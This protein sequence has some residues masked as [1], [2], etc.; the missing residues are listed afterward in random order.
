MTRK[1]RMILVM[2]ILLGVLLCGAAGADES[3]QVSVNAGFQCVVTRPESTAQLKQTV[4]LRTFS[5]TAVEGVH[6]KGSGTTL[7]FNAGETRKSVVMSYPVSISPT[8]INGVSKYQAGLAR[9][10]GVELMDEAG[11][12]LWSGVFSM[13]RDEQY[14]VQPQMINSKVENLL[15]MKDSDFASDMDGR[16]VD[17]SI[18]SPIGKEVTDSGYGQGKKTMNFSTLYSSVPQEYLKAIGGK[19]Y[20][21]AGFQ[22]KEEDDGW[23]YIQIL[24][25]E[26]ENYDEKDPKGD[27]D[28]PSKSVYKACFELSG[29]GDVNTSY[30]NQFFPHKYNSSSRL[31]AYAMCLI[32]VN[33]WAEF[34]NNNSRL[35]GQKFRTS[36]Y[37]ATDTGA[38]VLPASTNSLTIRFDAR[39]EDD[40]DWYYKDL[41][42][43]AA[44]CDNKAPQLT[45]VMVGN[46]SYAPGGSLNISLKFDEIV[47]AAGT[48]LN[49]SWGTLTC[50]FCDFTPCDVVTYRGAFTA[51]NVSA[52]ESLRITGIT[53]TIRDLAGNEFGAMEPRTMS[54]AVAAQPYNYSITYHLEGGT[55]TG[56]PASYTFQTDTFTLKYPTRKGFKFVGWTGYGL[57]GIVRDVTIPK[58]SRGRRVYTAIWTR[59]MDHPIEVGSWAELQSALNEGGAIRL[60]QDITAGAGD[61]TLTAPEGRDTH[62]DLAGH[63]LHRGLRGSLNGGNVITVRGELIVGDSAR[64]GKITGGNNDCFNAGDPITLGGGIYVV[65][66][67]SFTLEGGTI[68]D[69]RVKHDSGGNKAQGGGVYVAGGGSFTMKGGAIR[70]CLADAEAYYAEGGAVYVAAGASFTMTGGTISSCRAMIYRS[71]NEVRGGGIY[72]D[73][74]G[75]FTMTGGTVTNCRVRFMANESKAC[76]G[77]NVYVARNG[78]FNISGSPVIADHVGGVP[79]FQNIFLAIGVRIHVTAAL[80]ETARISL[81]T[82]AIPA[83]NASTVIADCP[84]G[85]GAEVNFVSDRTGYLFS[86]GNDEVRLMRQAAITSWA[87]LQEKLN[88][89]GYVTLTHNLTA[90]END[91]ALVIPSNVTVHLNLN[92]QKLDRGLGDQAARPGG[93]VLTVEGTLDLWDS[94][95]YSGGRVTGANNTGNGGGIYVAPGGTLTLSYGSPIRNNKAVNGGGV[96][97]SAGSTFSMYDL[98]AVNQN[99]RQDGKPSNIYLDHGTVINI[100]RTLYPY[101]TSGVTTAAIPTRDAPVVITS[102]LSGRGGVGGFKSDMSGC[103][104]MLNADSECVLGVIDFAQPDFRLPAAI[105][106][107]E[108]GAFEGAAMHVVYVPDG[109]TSVG[110]NAFLDCKNLT[111]IR[112]PKDCTIDPAAFSGCD[113]VYVFALKGGSTEAFCDKEAENCIFVEYEGHDGD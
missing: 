39:G 84:D 105:Q 64:T 29:S 101:N 26:E 7:T 20:A 22:M 14:R 112:L 47:Q 69:C 13:E 24:A 11:V 94:S 93:N 25:D 56:N 10:L 45:E 62:L 77:N 18:P 37:R 15:Y 3:F 83:E 21:V 96:Y 38:L 73:G 88:A 48:Q 28:T 103:A 52:G 49:T 75:T 82:Q 19:V 78:V 44:A 98:T 34:P 5:V 54:G 43:R 67:G 46:A 104:P 108:D 102:G 72:V 27:V 31:Q 59:D 68:E 81:Y 70:N 6:Y 97:V 71:E 85:Y 35:H 80:D 90:E 12:C 76:D 9:E 16:Y 17:I 36:G 113:T 107:V 89:G 66:G 100:P 87:A 32:P 95:T 91:S 2:T 4:T 110:A 8:I 53:G 51:T 86:L 106:T 30:C 58:G 50:D 33:E 79:D 55:D 61:E 23:Q 42:V 109:C 60:T 63:T 41:F 74:G 40:D 1:C 92:S 57:D 111:Q 65:S 99:Y